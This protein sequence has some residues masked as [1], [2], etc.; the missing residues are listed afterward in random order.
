MTIEVY[1]WVGK[2]LSR[3]LKQ[4]MRIDWLGERGESGWEAIL[5]VLNVGERS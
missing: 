3:V 5:K 4:V 1:V 2:Y